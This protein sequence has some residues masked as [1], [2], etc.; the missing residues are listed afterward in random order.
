[1]RCHQ[2]AQELA[3]AA[4]FCSRCGARQLQ[5]RV[6]KRCAFCGILPEPDRVYC[7]QCGHLL[8]SKTLEGAQ[9]NRIRSMDR[10]EGKPA[11]TNPRCCGDLVVYDDRVEFCRVLPGFGF[12]TPMPVPPEVYPMDSIRSARECRGVGLTRAVELTLEDGRVVGFYGM[13]STMVTGKAVSLIEE[14]LR[15]LKPADDKN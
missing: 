12:G 14:S 9:L 6:C 11:V 1:M 8:Q 4:R 13:F 15:W 7:D 2:C 10:Y 3:N 5:K